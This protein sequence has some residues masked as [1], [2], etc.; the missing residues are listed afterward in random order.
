MNKLLIAVFDNETAAN[1]GLQALHKL[2]AQGEITVYAT[3]VI[4]KDANGKVSLKQSADSGPIGT[5]VG[6]AVGSLIGL[7]GGP[8][9]LAV[10]AMTGTVVGAMRD[11]WV[12]GVGLDFIEEAETLLLPGKV[13]L[14]AEIEE[15]WVIPVDTALEAAGGR[16][17]RRSRTEVSEVQFDHDIAAFQAEIKELESEAS[18]AGGAAKEKL[19][20]KIAAAKGSLDAA[21]QRGQQRV[22]ALKQ[23]ADA[24]VEALKVQLTQAKGDMKA[25][26]EERVKHVKIAYHARGAK[27]SQAWHLTKEALAV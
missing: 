10:G 18:D 14:L 15:E 16:L 26:I 11:F 7:L 17:L 23:E 6:L 22:D 24:K 27:L 1:T 20:A 9:G 8:M 4:A 21:V 5:G 25:R 13:A 2:H 19:H 12:A 3:G